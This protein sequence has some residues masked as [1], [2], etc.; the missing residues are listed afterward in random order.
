M[1]R[2]LVE[3]LLALVEQFDELRDTAGIHELGSLWFGFRALI[4]KDDL[5]A[6]V[7]EGQLS[8]TSSQRV[9]VEDRGFHD[10]GVGLERDARASLFAGLTSFGERALGNAERILLHPGVAGA[11]ILAI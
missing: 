11:D 3:N 7:E 4:G 6:F 8:Q 9:K 2:L 1:D 10:G 5:E